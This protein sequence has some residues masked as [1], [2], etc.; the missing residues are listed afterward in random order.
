VSQKTQQPPV[1]YVPPA[2]RAYD[3]ANWIISLFGISF[4]IMPPQRAS[5]LVFLPPFV[6]GTVV[7]FLHNFKIDLI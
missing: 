6:S 5:C 7:F 3:S 2:L 1:G 4:G